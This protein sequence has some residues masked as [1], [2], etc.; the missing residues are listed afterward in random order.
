MEDRTPHMEGIMTVELASE[1]RRLTTESILEAIEDFFRPLRE[2]AHWVRVFV[3]VPKLLSPLEGL[4]AL[5]LHQEETLAAVHEL[6]K[7]IGL[8]AHDLQSHE[9]ALDSSRYKT[10]DEF[11]ALVDFL[12]P[13]DLRKRVGTERRVFQYLTMADDLW[14]RGEGERAGEVL[15]LLG[16]IGERHQ[17]SSSLIYVWFNL[18]ELSFEQNRLS[19]AERYFQRI[20]G[21]NEMH[22]F[23]EVLAAAYSRLAL[24]Y[25]YKRNFDK[26]ADYAKRALEIFERGGQRDLLLQSYVQLA[27]ALI[28]QGSSEVAIKALEE[29]TDASASMTHF[30]LP[31]PSLKR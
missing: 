17:L 16:R 26:T 13:F 24:V 14:R 3:H 18:G 21:R 22:E 30:L 28:E 23:E 1:I 15:R 10:Q 8:I 9:V 11:A 4:P 31:N 6:E 5:L 12:R 7:K 29:A 25:Y 2:A 19:R 20:V 27:S